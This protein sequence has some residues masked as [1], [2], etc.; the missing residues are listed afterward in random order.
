MVSEFCSVYWNIFLNILPVS[1]AESDKLTLAAGAAST[2]VFENSANIVGVLPDARLY[3]DTAG[4]VLEGEQFSSVHVVE[5]DDD[6][7]KSVCSPIL[8]QKEKGNTWYSMEIKSYLTI[9]A[10]SSRNS[11]EKLY[12]EILRPSVQTDDGKGALIGCLYLDMCLELIEYLRRTRTNPSAL[13]LTSCT[14]EPLFW[15]HFLSSRT[16]KEGFP[17]RFIQGAA[18]WDSKER[19]SILEHVHIENPFAEFSPFADAYEDLFGRSP[20]YHGAAGFSLLQLSMFATVF[21]NSTQPSVLLKVLD[22]EEGITTPIGHVRYRNGRNVEQSLIPLVQYDEHRKREVVA[23]NHKNSD[24]LVLPKPEWRK[25]EC[26]T[27]NKCS[28]GEC[29]ADGDCNC[30]FGYIGDECEYNLIAIVVG[31]VGSFVVILVGSISIL[32]YRYRQQKKHSWEDEQKRKQDRTMATI[33]QQSHLRALSFISHRLR[34]PTHC[35]AGTV[36]MLLDTVEFENMTTSYQEKISLL[37]E[38]IGQITGTL[39]EVSMTLDFGSNALPTVTD[40]GS[41]E[42]NASAN[43]STAGW[44]ASTGGSPVD[45]ASKQ[46]K[47]VITEDKFLLSDIVRDLKEQINTAEIAQVRTLSIRVPSVTADGKIDFMNKLELRKAT[48][49][50]CSLVVAHKALLMEILSTLHLC[51]GAMIKNALDRSRKDIRKKYP[52]YLKEWRSIENSGDFDCSKV[53]NCVSGEN[54]RSANETVENLPTLSVQNHSSRAVSPFASYV[55][56]MEVSCEVVRRTEIGTKDDVDKGSRNR[57]TRNKGRNRTGMDSVGGFAIQWEASFRLRPKRISGSPSVADGPS[58][59]RASHN[60]DDREHDSKEQYTCDGNLDGDDAEL[61]LT[62]LIP[63]TWST[64]IVDK[65]LRRIGG[66]Y[67][68]FIPDKRVL[69]HAIIAQEQMVLERK[70]AIRRRKLSSYDSYPLH[71]V[72]SQMSSNSIIST[73]LNRGL[74]PSS[75]I[76]GLRIFI[77]IEVSSQNERTMEEVIDPRDAFQKMRDNNE[78]G[79]MQRPR[80]GSCP[81]SKITDFP[82]ITIP[83][84][85]SENLMDGMASMTASLPT[86]EVQ[87]KL[88]NQNDPSKT[89]DPECKQSDVTPTKRS[90]HFLIVDDEKTNRLI[91]KKLVTKKGHKATLANDGSE[92]ESLLS[93]TNQIQNYAEESDQKC[94]RAERD[95]S[96]TYDAILLDIVMH[97]MNGDVACYNLRQRGCR[98]PIIATTGNAS[99]RDARR[100]KK[101]GFDDVVH[102]PFTVEA[103]KQALAASNLLL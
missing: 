33:A 8:S 100:Y 61:R 26:Q 35:M 41:D 24:T 44:T 17:G 95:S 28:N 87:P 80:A 6:F 55:L 20:T 58:S 11:R 56:A 47:R 38:C 36:H 75:P 57:G 77:P 63:F 103:L 15:E 98:L 16:E 49:S 72:S 69:S 91:L 78:E 102:K 12:E 2:E 83:R 90:L 40:A 65:Q 86:N 29:T 42:D 30:R 96:E 70:D 89:S 59:T 60:N 93:R 37:K 53:G 92:I 45:S 23:P 9:S 39:D 18:V 43:N 22:T 25:L 14:Q 79:I 68:Q 66:Y 54:R 94:N 84:M 7:P 32:L 67:Q 46:G 1:L 27:E 31:V 88:S 19:K 101:M 5:E 97:T 51:T 76:G 81:I 10:N 62:S 13:L 71:T 82:K 3:F 48:E 52:K 64:D 99:S 34:N 73:L 85:H 74:T 50:N 21:T 4:R